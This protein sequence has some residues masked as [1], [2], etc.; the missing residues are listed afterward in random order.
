MVKKVIFSPEANE[1]LKDIVYY[2]IDKWSANQ[3]DKFLVLLDNKIK[4][5]QLFP[6]SYPR[7]RHKVKIHKCVITKQISLYY[8][9]KQ[10]IIEVITL[11]DSR[12]DAKKLILP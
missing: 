7:I 9:V 1:R 6:H 11:F 8:R 2:L 12:Q 3:A 4:N 10:D 5:L